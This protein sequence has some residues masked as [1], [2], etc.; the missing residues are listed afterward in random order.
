MGANP[1]IAKNAPSLSRNEQGS[2][3]GSCFVLLPH[4]QLVQEHSQPVQ[5][6]D[7]FKS[8]FKAKSKTILLSGLDNDADHN[9]AGVASVG[10]A[11]RA[12]AMIEPKT[13]QFKDAA[14]TVRRLA[15]L[16]L[17]CIHITWACRTQSGPRHR[18]LTD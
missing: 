15:S 11:S 13:Q 2:N 1:K 3:F 12:I 9:L 17:F 8:V 10:A 4:L 6:H 7:Y 5:K 16:S 18:S 14:E